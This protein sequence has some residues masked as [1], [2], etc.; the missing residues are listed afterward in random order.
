MKNW[1][2]LVI[3]SLSVLTVYPQVSLTGKVVDAENNA[4]LSNVIVMLRNSQGRVIKYTQTDN[5]GLFSLNVSDDMASS[6]NISFSLMSYKTKSYALKGN[7]QELNV[8]LEQTSIHIKEVVVKARRIGEQGD[9]LIYNV[10]G[11]ATEQDK[12]IGDV[13]KKMPGIN[14]DK[15]GK[16][17]YNGVDINK[18]YIEG[19]D[20]L[21]GRYGIATKGIS[22]RDVGRVE[23]MEN[24]QPIKVMAGFSFSDQAAINLKLKDR[25]KAQWVGTFES[26]GG[27]SGSKN[28]LWNSVLFGMLIKKSMQNITTLKS[29]N[30]GL[31]IGNDIQNFYQM[32]GMRTVQ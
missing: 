26:E 16:I 11:F 7:N 29:N 4:S 3:L 2:M 5:D 1:L 21:E 28:V 24:H 13:L 18:F 10:A 15:E 19:K 22:Y 8:C 30:T 31:N 12:S 27:Y 32:R 9:T 17:K 6:C 23:V 25:A 20:L 14:V